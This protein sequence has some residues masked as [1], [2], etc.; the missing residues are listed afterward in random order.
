MVSVCRRCAGG[1]GSGPLAIEAV[2]M[3]GA[4]AAAHELRILL[5]RLDVASETLLSGLATPRAYRLAPE[6]RAFP[7]ITT[8]EHPLS[9]NSEESM[10]SMSRCRRTASSSA[11]SALARAA[12][13]S[14]SRFSD[15]RKALPSSLRVTAT[16]SLRE[17]MIPLLVRRRPRLGPLLDD[18]LAIAECDFTQERSRESRGCPGGHPRVRR[19]AFRV[20]RCQIMAPDRSGILGRLN[21]RS[22]L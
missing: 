18:R 11:L 7:S 8:T 19:I 13:V 4:G 16:L 5:M 1:A 10:S 2:S 22:R 6:V 12:E 9:H 15:S 17:T 3:T 21:G 14:W 20:H